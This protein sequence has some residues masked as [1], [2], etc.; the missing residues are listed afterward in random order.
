[1]PMNF[2]VLIDIV[3]TMK[4]FNFGE[5]PTPILDPGSERIS[6]RERDHC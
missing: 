3:L 2:R 5:D 1:M 6:M 4:G